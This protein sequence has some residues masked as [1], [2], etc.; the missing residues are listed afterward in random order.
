MAFRA[1]PSPFSGPST[2]S[3]EPQPQTGPDLE[4]IQTE[5][6]ITGLAIKD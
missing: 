6:T 2:N 1:S 4:E 5:V 3:G